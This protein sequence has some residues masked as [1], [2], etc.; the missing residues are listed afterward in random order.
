MPKARSKVTPVP[1]KGALRILGWIRRPSPGRPESPYEVLGPRELRDLGL[2]CCLPGP[3]YDR[4]F[5]KL[6]WPL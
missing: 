1:S 2:P 4:R 6:S 3:P 5:A